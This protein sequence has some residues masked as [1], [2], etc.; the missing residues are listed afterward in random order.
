MK[1]R[2]LSMSLVVAMAAVAMTGCGGNSGSSDKSGDADTIKIGGMGPITGGAAYYG[3]EVKQGSQIAID[4]I[5]EAGGINGMKIEYNF[6]DDEADAEKAVN[7]YN[8]L[9]DWGVQVI[10]GATTSD[11]TISLAA[12]T[13]NDNVFQITP[14][15]SSVD[16]VTNPNAYQVCFSDPNQGIASAQYIAEN[17]LATKIAVIYDS[18]SSYSS[19]NY[20]NFVKKAK[21]E[22]LDI[23][24][25]GA[26]TASNNTDFSVQ[27]QD[28]KNNGAELVFLP[29]YYQQACIIFEAGT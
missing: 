23:V 4:E 19:G 16:C 3:T 12:E 14:S 28:A 7:A 10:V 15:G 2:F 13:A 18:S 24:S 25:T 26:F 20:E 22:G 6:Q 21:E 29:V 1:K 27:L 9:K 17:K 8:T 5:N 11:A